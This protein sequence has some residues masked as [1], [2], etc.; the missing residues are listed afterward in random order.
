MVQRV[1]RRPGVDGGILISY[2]ALTNTTQ[3]TSTLISDT[4][5]ANSTPTKA[6]MVVFG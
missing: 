4:F 3:N 5:T 1:E 2:S 6:R